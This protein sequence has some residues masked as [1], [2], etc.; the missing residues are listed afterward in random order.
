MKSLVRAVAF[1]DRIDGKVSHPDRMIAIRHLKPFERFFAAV[2]RRIDLGQTVRRNVTL[3]RDCFQFVRDLVR[4]TLPPC[5]RKGNRDLRYAE[6][7]TVRDSQPSSVHSRPRCVSR[8][9]RSPGRAQGATPRSWSPA[10]LS[11]DFVRW[12][13]NSYVPCSSEVPPMC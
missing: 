12:R 4:F 6:W 9:E 11:F 13:R 1:K 10:Q 2:Q 8:P 3:P 5:R 7:A